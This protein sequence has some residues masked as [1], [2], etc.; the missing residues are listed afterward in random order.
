MFSKHFGVVLT[1]IMAAMAAVSVASSH[2]TESTS[3]VSMVAPAA[4]PVDE[5]AGLLSGVQ[6]FQA[7][8]VQFIADKTGA[9]QQTSG[10]LKARKPG[11]FYWHTDPPLEQVV[12][13]DGEKVSVFDPDLEQ[14]TIQKMDEEK[15]QSPAM[16][17]SGDVAKIKATY[18]VTSESMEGVRVFSLVPL[19]KESLFDRLQ[20]KFVQGT[21]VEMRLRDGLG[22]KTTLSFLNVE[23]NP[24]LSDA[25]FELQLPD[26][27]D[28]IA[29]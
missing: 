7:Q 23:M 19:S 12:V 8:F 14:V 5:L 25:D 29:E 10:T 17:L 6:T 1:I 4:E 2:A 3:A 18:Q 24:S 15:R 22:Q 28:I 21:L 9:I 27:V 11:Y 13:S 20:M 16:L 26:G